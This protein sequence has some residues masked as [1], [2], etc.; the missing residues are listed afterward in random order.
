MFRRSN[1][2]NFG[3]FWVIRHL[4]HPRDTVKS[5]S[6]EIIKKTRK[7]KYLQPVTAMT[8]IQ[9]EIMRPTVPVKSGLLIKFDISCPRDTVKSQ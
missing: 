9:R 1:L 4:S 8:I 6:I 2:D 5:Y 7:Q 3:K